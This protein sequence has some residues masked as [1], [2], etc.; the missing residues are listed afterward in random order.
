MM[1]EEMEYAILNISNFYN[2]EMN[3]YFYYI[4]AV[5]TLVRSEIH[6]QFFTEDGN[7][8]TCARRNDHLLLLEVKEC[9]GFRTNPCF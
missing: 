4:P 7:V 3:L 2:D 5:F 9:H 8:F 1:C 6:T